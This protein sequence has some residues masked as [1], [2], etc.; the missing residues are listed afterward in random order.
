MS[1]KVCEAK[2]WHS[3]RVP[4]EFF[5]ADYNRAKER[6]T[7]SSLLSLF[8]SFHHH[9]KKILLKKQIFFSKISK[10][11]LLNLPHQYYLLLEFYSLFIP[12]FSYFEWKLDDGKP[13]GRWRLAEIGWSAIVSWW[14][15]NLIKINWV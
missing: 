13:F 5:G 6:K 11:L 3:S 2:E 1:A 7:S 8:F 12:Q 10:V 15:K 4:N 9:Q 14:W